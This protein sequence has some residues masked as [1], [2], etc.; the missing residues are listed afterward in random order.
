VISRAR[1]NSPDVDERRDEACEEDLR[2]YVEQH[3]PRPDVDADV[4]DR[5]LEEGP[6]A[7]AADEV[8]KMVG[9][10]EGGGGA[11]T[12]KRSEPVPEPPPYE[13][14]GCEL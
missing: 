7:A 10:F 13:E 11:A 2:E 8:G 5:Y 6:P 12:G 3:S 9:G 14:P 1:G 4:L